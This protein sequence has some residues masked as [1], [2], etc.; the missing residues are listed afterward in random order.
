MII[1][2]TRTDLFSN[3]QLKLVDYVI[4]NPPYVRTQ[5]LGS[6]RAQKIAKSFNLSGR[7]DIY[8]AFIKGIAKILKPGGIAGIIVSN[9][10]MSTKTGKSIRKDIRQSFEILHVWDF[11]DTKIFDAAVL[12]AVLI[13]RKK[14][15]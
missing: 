3:N 10:F 7:I 1:E 11:G 13:L 5:N 4:A 12:P 14:L 15:I 9:R 2:Q 8:Q 6:K